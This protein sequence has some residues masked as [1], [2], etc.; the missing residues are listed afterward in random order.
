MAKDTDGSFVLVFDGKNLRTITSYIAEDLIT[1]NFYRFKVSAFNF[2]GEGSNSLVLSTYACIAPSIMTSPSRVS[3]TLS[4]FTL[5]WE[6]PSDDGGCPII[7]YAVFRNDG[8]SGSI[9]TEVNSDY[10]TN[11]RD[12]PT[13]RFMQINSYPLNKIGKTFMY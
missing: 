2:N 10:D 8:E 1:G 11:I 5:S 12:K 13:L 6:E 9:N 7:G 3:S 4:Q